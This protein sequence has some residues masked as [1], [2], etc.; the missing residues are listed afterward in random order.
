MRAEALKVD[1][2]SIRSL[3]ERSKSHARRASKFRFWPVYQRSE[4]L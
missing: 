2:V 4:F 1:L 3:E